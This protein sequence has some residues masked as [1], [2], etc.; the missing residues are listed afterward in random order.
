MI[1]IVVC[2]HSDKITIELEENIA[3]TIGVDYEII[4]INNIDNQYSIFQAYNIGVQEAKY[5][6]I[7]FMHEDIL[8][9]TKNWGKKLV[10]YFHN[11]NIGMIGVAGPTYISRIPGIWWGI[12]NKY[13]TTNSTRQYNMDTD[14][15][16]RTNHHLTLNNPYKED[17]SDVVALDGLF[18]C[19]PK[20]LFKKI[21]F[22]EKFSG[23]HFYDLDISMQIN[24]LGY[25]IICVYDILVEH[26]SR[27]NLSK[28]WILASRKFFTKWSNQLP[29]ASCKYDR[30]LKRKMEENNF[31]TMINIL[32]GNQISIFKYYTFKEMLGIVFKCWHV[33]LKKILTKIC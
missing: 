4:S 9:H 21:S 26:I 22:D 24:Q 16:D 6:L 17:V 1:S 11:P 8:Y 5:D 13:N 29:I 10:A 30:K 20:R 28:D 14:R 7:C 32:S 31:Q 25:K 18:F 33:I 15:F 3:E 23:F 19:I 12:N 27:A 2:S